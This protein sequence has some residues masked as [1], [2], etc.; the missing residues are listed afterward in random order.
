MPKLAGLRPPTATENA[1][2]SGVAA[3]EDVPKGRNR[4]GTRLA[5]KNGRRLLLGA[6]RVESR[7]E[8]RIH[9]R[10]RAWQ[11]PFERDPPR[12]RRGGLVE[13][14][15]CAWAASIARRYFEVL[16]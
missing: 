1:K 3:L 2:G 8:A 10:Y 12:R 5:A 4:F 16:P 15:L 7:L 13:R 9:V 6:L 14:L 11:R